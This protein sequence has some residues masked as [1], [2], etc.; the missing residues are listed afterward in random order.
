M[1]PDNP[2][3]NTLPLYT[4][5]QTRELDRLAIEVAGIPGYTLMT[6]AGEAGWE[7]LRAHWPAARALTVVCGSGNNGGDGFV[8]ARL[9]RNAGWQVQVLQLG[10]ES[11]SQDD[12][13]KARA[14]YVAVGGQ[15][16]AFNEA[17][18]ASSD[19][20]VDALL[21]TGLERPLEGD[22]RAA[23]EA[24][25]RAAQPVF[26]LDIPSGL[27]ADTGA[28]LGITVKA[29]RTITFIG[30]KQGL[31][32]GQGPE[33]T[34]CL[35]FDDLGVPATILRQV[36]VTTNL[37]HRP[38]LG[39]LAMPRPRSAHKGQHGHVLVV[40]GAR[41]MVGA[42]RLAGEAA[43]R[44]GTGLVSLATRP[45][46]AASIAAACPELMSHGVAAAAELRPL[47]GRASV[48]IAGPGL[49]TSGWAQALLAQLLESGKPL[50]MD[51][52]ALNLLAREP[53]LRDNW[54]LTPHPGEAA[55]LLQ[56]DAATVQADRF[57]AAKDIVSRYGGTV[58]LK[59]AG[60]LIV[61]TDR[62]LAVCA[63][64]NP[65]MAT[66]GMGDVLSGVIAG[67]IAQGMELPAAAVAG[68]C[69]HGCAGDY[70]ARAGERGMTARDVIGA[71]RRVI[72]GTGE[73]P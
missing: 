21:G 24:V 60:T 54:V 19:I 14:A 2:D 65:G 70:A 48:V 25:N 3:S 63:A 51:A 32:T 50:V 17:A 26:A 22:W 6:R 62:P 9:A 35:D 38:H 23:V 10:E 28:S 56:Q 59:G 11:R 69:V 71:V 73:G 45:E 46:H 30:R 53:L 49:G 13:L 47:L 39:A 40:G 1:K 43:L 31:F 55:R 61:T 36:A 33:Y 66:A 57:T 15:V 41:G 64:G 5:A 42:A 18:L 37:H 34:G 4:A 27:H 8:L 68:V 16:K 20:I 29:S 52:D 72:N 58:V 67:L 44:A 12:A 7:R